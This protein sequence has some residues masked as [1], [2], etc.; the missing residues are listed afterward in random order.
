MKCKQC[1]DFLGGS[2][3]YDS[4]CYRCVVVLMAEGPGSPNY[5]E[6]SG[7]YWRAQFDQWAQETPPF[8]KTP[9]NP[10]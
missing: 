6:A 2:L 5:E 1:D 3:D 8:W 4:F 7:E 10:A 9:I